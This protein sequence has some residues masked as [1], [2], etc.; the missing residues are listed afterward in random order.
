MSSAQE[1]E[2]YAAV[3]GRCKSSL[4]DAAF[5]KR[6]SGTGWWLASF[7]LWTSRPYWWRTR[8]LQA[9]RWTAPWAGAPSTSRSAGPTRHRRGKGRTRRL[10][11]LPVWIF[12]CRHLCQRHTTRFHLL[13]A[14]SN[15]IRETRF[16]LSKRLGAKS[17]LT[18]SK[19]RLPE[20]SSEIKKSCL[21]RAQSI[22]GGTGGECF[23]SLAKP[24]HVDLARDCQHFYQRANST[25]VGKWVKAY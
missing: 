8:G 3:E 5:C 11:L 16:C 24:H 19:V 15:G 9:W 14:L 25:L 2:R 21:K 13:P 4:C 7:H 23:Q 22:T 1:A 20:F 18:R 17:G 12:S 6:D 10:L